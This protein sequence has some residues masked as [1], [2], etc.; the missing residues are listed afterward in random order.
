MYAYRLLKRFKAL[1]CGCAVYGLSWL[2]T[3]YYT[4]MYTERERAPV[5]TRS[6]CTGVMGAVRLHLEESV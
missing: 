6:D 2:K 1:L 4:H 5:A 3:A